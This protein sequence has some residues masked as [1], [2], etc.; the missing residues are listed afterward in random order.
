VG[1]PPTRVE[2]VRDPG[3]RAYFTR[4]TERTR[5]AIMKA[6]FEPPLELL[7]MDRVDIEALPDAVAKLPSTS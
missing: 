6:M 3:T 5:A 7:E 2:R 1:T 4:Y